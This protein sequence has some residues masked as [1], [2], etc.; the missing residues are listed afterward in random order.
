MGLPDEIE[1]GVAVRQMKS[2]L[3]L[4]HAGKKTEQANDH[5]TVRLLRYELE[6]Y[7]EYIKFGYLAGDLLASR[8]SEGD[9]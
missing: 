3:G 5:E 9:A 6:G 2:A 8:T 4:G 7:H 1:G